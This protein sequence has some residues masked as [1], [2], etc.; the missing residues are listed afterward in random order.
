MSQKRSSRPASGTQTSSTDKSSSRTGRKRRYPTPDP[1]E[2]SSQTY[3]R[4]HAR[5]AALAAVAAVEATIAS[6]N[7][8]LNLQVTHEVTH[9]S[10]MSGRMKV[11]EWRRRH[12]AAMYA[13]LGVTPDTFTK[14]PDEL[15]IRGG[16]TRTR[17]CETAHEMGDGNG[18][19]NPT[20]Q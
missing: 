3:R 8:T 18:L 15:E 12:S 2:A 4:K 19:K 13:Q 17:G 1:T 20:T 5:I 6:L 16:L 7:G 11:Q 9:D 14:I 10:Q